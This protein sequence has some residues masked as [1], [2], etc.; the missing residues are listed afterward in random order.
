MG[1]WRLGLPFFLAILSP[2]QEGTARGA[3]PSKLLIE[4]EG[5]DLR[6]Q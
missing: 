1:I 2:N 5:L 3:K 4:I 6:H